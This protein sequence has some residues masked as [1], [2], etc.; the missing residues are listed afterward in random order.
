VRIEFSRQAQKALVRSNKR[1][2]ILS[3]VELLASDPSLLAN[4]VIQLKGRA[5]FRLRVQDW[6]IIFLQQDGV[7]LIREILPRASAYED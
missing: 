6:R 4:N 5:E 7:I 1:A 3:K 2:L